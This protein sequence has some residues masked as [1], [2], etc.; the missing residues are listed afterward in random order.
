MDG[1]REGQ[2]PI[3]IG[4]TRKGIGPTYEDKISR[5]G[6]KLKDLLDESVLRKKLEQS[7]VE[8]RVL[9]E[10]LY[11]IPYPSVAEEA[12]RLCQL[13]EQLRPFL[14]DTFS[15][16]GAAANEGKKILFE[17]AQ[18][19][20][21]D[22]D[23]GSYPFVTSSHTSIG[24]VYT[25]AGVPG[26]RVEEALGIVKAYTTRVGNGP[27]PTELDCSIGKLLQQKGHE[28]GA[29]TGRQRRCGWLDLPLLK[30]T[31]KA[32]NLT[33]IA[34]TKVDVLAG[35]DSL[36][37]CY[38]YKYRGETLSCSSPHLDLYEVEPLYED[39]AP[40]ADIF[41]EGGEL[42]RELQ[43]YISHI[44]DF[45]GVPVG[46]LSFGPDREQIRFLKEYF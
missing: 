16:I 3:K 31:V 42:S 33:S 6:I 29:T 1:Q 40:F 45:I 38:A 27:F 14:S 25:G 32:S 4:T 39:F 24:G 9:F 5:Q 20:L 11:K 35:M 28:F 13:G 22:V 7:L 23:Y 30:Y 19:I 12:E 8:K 2:G 44:E 18:G 17:G 36:K 37:V 41:C 34:L 43:K 15:L 10:H 21:L 46:V 26:G